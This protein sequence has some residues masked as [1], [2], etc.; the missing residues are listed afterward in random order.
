MY[1]FIIM[2]SV[3]IPD[4]NLSSASK[5]KAHLFRLKLD[6]IVI[7]SLKLAIIIHNAIDISLGVTI[8]L[9]GMDVVQIWCRIMVKSNETIKISNIISNTVSNK[10]S[11]RVYLWPVSPIHRSK[12]AYNKRIQKFV[13]EIIAFILV[14]II[15]LNPILVMQHNLVF[16][17]FKRFFYVPTELF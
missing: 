5:N 9:Y 2:S 17:I 14:V 6:R 7:A 1:H 10:I 3:E 12:S 4:T 15:F 13:L 16:N 11:D 8:W